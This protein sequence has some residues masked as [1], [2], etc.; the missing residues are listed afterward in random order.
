MHGLFRGMAPT[1][2]GI[3]PYSG[4]SFCIFET[5]KERYKRYYQTDEIPLSLRLGAG[6]VA[7]L[8]GQLCSYPFHVVRRR[9]QIYEASARG[10]GRGA[11]QASFVQ[12]T[13]AIWH[14]EG[15]RRGFFKGE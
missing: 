7:G 11:P 14:N 10:S 1:I 12:T 4:M 15:V 5:T 3:I 9:M 6:G 2:F 13:M 8:V